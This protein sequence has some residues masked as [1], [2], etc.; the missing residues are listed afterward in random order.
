RR[1]FGEAPEPVRLMG[2]EDLEEV[3]RFIRL[4]DTDDYKA[5]KIAF[6]HVGFSQPVERDA[7][8]VLIE[9]DERRPVGVIGY[10][11]DDLEAHGTYWLGWT[12]VN[13]FFRGRGYGSKL[14]VYVK[15]VLRELAARKLF[16]ST[17]GLEKYAAAVSFYERHGFTQEGRLVDFYADGDDKILMGC[18]IASPASPRTSHLEDARKR[19]PDPTPPKPDE[20][21]DPSGGSSPGGGVV[22]EF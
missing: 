9:P 7:H 16:L 8:F 18:R 11:I 17:S 2:P 6:E 3:L 19:R 1:L 13:P 21:D 15:E 14:M 20:D 22:F 5:A 12:Y 10:S 4:H